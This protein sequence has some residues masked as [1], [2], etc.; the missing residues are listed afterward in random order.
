MLFAESEKELQRV[1]G[2]F[3]SECPRRKRKVN[4]GKSK[5]MIFKRREV[6]VVDFNT[7]Y[8]V[9]VLERCEVSSRKREN[10][11]SKRV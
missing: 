1:V 4:G 8:R 7:P 10:G 3:Y 9:S 11:G 5:V 2:E 6:E